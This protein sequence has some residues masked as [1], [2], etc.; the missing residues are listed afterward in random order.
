MDTVS[1]ISTSSEGDSIKIFLRVR[2]PDPSISENDF[3]PRVLDVNTADNAIIL[4][5]KP[6][7]KIFTYDNVADADI[8]QEAV[9]SIVGKKI[10]ESC[11]TGY[12]GTIFAYG[13]TGS[14]KTFTMLGPSENSESFQHELRGVIPRSFEYLFSLIAHQQELHG[15]KKQFLCRCSFLEIYQEQIFDLLDTASQGLH[16][17][18]NMNKGVFVDGLIEQVICNP[19][20]AYQVLIMGWLNRRVAATSMNRES[21]RSHA[22]F[23][24]M[25]ESKEDVGGVQN[26]RTSQLNLV[27]LAGSERQK[28]TNT[29]GTRLKEAGSINKSLSV[30]GNV[31]MSLVDLSHGKKRHIPY[32]DSKL[33]FLLR[34]SLGGNTKTR[35]IACVHPDSRCFGETLS[36]LNFARSAKLIK[37]KAV[38][39]EDIHGNNQKLQNEIRRLKELLESMQNSPGPE[40]R[41]NVVTPSENSSS[42]MDADS[43]WKKNFLEA[44]FFREQSE[45]EKKTLQDVVNHLQELCNKK[46]K[47]IQSTK[48]IIKFREN[49]IQ[50][51]QQASKGYIE[52]EKDT[53]VKT[54]KDEIKVLRQQLE[55]NPLL[56]KYAGENKHLRSEL[57]QL[58]ARESLSNIHNDV[59]RSAQL[60]RVFKELKLYKELSTGSPCGGIRA[61]PLKDGLS[62]ATLE[63]HRREIKGYQEQVEN[64]RQQLQDL[65]KT[66]EN[67]QMEMEV[68]LVSCRR[69]IVE[70]ERVLEAHQLK[71]RIE[72]NALKD[73][74]CQTLK[75]M[76]TPKMSANSPNTQ[77]QAVGEML[78]SEMGIT[79]CILQKDLAEGA[80]EALMDEIRMLQ[81]ENGKLKERIDEYEADMLR[82]KQQV[83]KLE[84]FNSQ[85]NSVLD[86]E[87]AENIARR[88]DYTSAVNTLKE[89]IDTV[90]NDLKLLNDEN[91]DLHLVLKSADK[92]L[93]EEKESQKAL[94]HAYTQEIQSLETKLSKTS[95]D[96]ETTTRDY[97]EALKEL[98]ALKEELETARVTMSFLENHASE[99]EES[100]N[101]E[102]RKREKLE[103]EF[104]A[105]KSAGDAVCRE[106]DANLDLRVAELEA[107]LAL[108]EEQDK[109]IQ[110]QEKLIEENKEIIS[111]LMNKMHEMKLSVTGL[112]ASNMNLKSEIENYKIDADE[113]KKDLEKTSAQLM[114]TL[115]KL[116]EL[117]QNYETALQRKDF[118]ISNLQEDQ[119]SANATMFRQAEMLTSLQDQLQTKELLCKEKS[120]M[121]D[122]LRSKLEEKDKALQETLQRFKDHLRE[123]NSSDENTDGLKK[124]LNQKNLE[125]ETMH[126]NNKKLS[127][128][129]Q[130]YEQTRKERNEENE[131]LKVQVAELERT[132]ENLVNRMQEV[133]ELQITVNTM[134]ANNK[135]LVKSLESS[136]KEKEHEVKQEQQRNRELDAKLKNLLQEKES[137]EAQFKASKLE[138]QNNNEEIA[139]LQ[140]ILD[141]HYTEKTE[142]SSKIESLQ[143]E[144]TKLKDELAA[145]KELNAQLVEESNR[146]IGHTNTNQKIRLFDKKNQEYNELTKKY[147]ELQ[148]EHRKVLQ[149]LKPQNKL[150]NTPCGKTGTIRDITNIN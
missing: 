84:L 134:R 10:I 97:E 129:L 8:T 139:R 115:Q 42:Y 57:K 112:E 137:I 98:G 26:I 141:N 59:S 15:S 38:V 101:R 7:P 150:P 6:E 16:L 117:K 35:M 136:L 37:N 58:R 45:N 34:D 65:T 146:I 100:R 149:E 145:L 75:V 56:A 111:N 94:H 2:P 19:S 116:T 120:I 147:I 135:D 69:M 131:H 54:L 21:S 30:L 114:N 86:K 63:K 23:T 124:L 1:S 81:M 121:I 142:L 108:K 85:L 70:L 144:K 104:R 36:T 138:E 24:V 3:A 140:K 43:I 46:D 66:S 127:C 122:E 5:T 22:V 71:A 109:T 95:I 133:E 91:T 32:R 31:I 55:N 143:E 40:I 148:N 74:H 72:C 96:L 52:I 132:K 18:E 113:A 83:E 102:I 118:Q 48:M 39:N 76:T 80:H 68:E 28:D 123:V 11:V 50:S 9:F 51:L 25:I 77:D 106:P 87:R 99:I 82:Q 53:L 126:V 44:M 119:D 4:R 79:D 92:Q 60:E 93:K 64:L 61:S 105:L 47:Y 73:L 41:P 125:L 110:Q 29:G 130:E 49:T 12:N 107:T 27:D 90:K 67:R 88:N 78:D 128:M 20:D 33:T 13:Q 14:G 89:E 17:R 103:Q 62:A